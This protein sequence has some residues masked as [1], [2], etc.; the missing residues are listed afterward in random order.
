MV[1]TVVA[2]SKG[3]HTESRERLVWKSWRHCLLSWGWNSIFK[4]II[5]LH[6]YHRSLFPNT[7]PWFKCL[8]QAPPKVEMHHNAHQSHNWQTT[9]KLGIMT[10]YR[11][12]LFF[13]FLLINSRRLVWCVFRYSQ[14]IINSVRSQT[15]ISSLEDEQYFDVP[16][17]I[18]YMFRM[19]R[20]LLLRPVAT[21]LRDEYKWN[22]W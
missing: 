20:V 17:L 19:F 7:T 21:V 13:I 18:H 16:R 3:D 11:N 14:N 8:I 15:A 6:K 22:K 2:V 10:S 1:A 9:F 4:L 12:S 5:I